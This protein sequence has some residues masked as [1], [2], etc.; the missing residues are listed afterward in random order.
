MAIPGLGSKGAAGPPVKNP[1]ENPVAVDGGGVFHQLTASRELSCTKER[2]AGFAP[3]QPDI[4]EL[5]Q[6]EGQGL[7]P[8]PDCFKTCPT[9]SRPCGE[10]GSGG[11][12]LQMCESRL[13]RFTSRAGSPPVWLTPTKEWQPSSESQGTVGE[14]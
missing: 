9:L 14:F 10:T 13:I 2:L 7:M 11:A 12:H 3:H 8:C 4:I 1:P 6:A 5:K